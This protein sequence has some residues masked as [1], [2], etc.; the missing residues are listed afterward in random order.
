M[1]AGDS[2]SPHQF[3]LQVH[4]E[5]KTERW[6]LPKLRVDAQVEGKTIGSLSVHQRLHDGDQAPVGVPNVY[7]NEEHQ[8]KGVATAM[9][10]EV[11]RRWPD[12]PIQH[13]EHASAAAQA[14]NRTL[15]RGEKMAR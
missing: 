4:E 7:V 11:K 8:R 5:P 14:L 12:V 6:G 15:G 2:L 3:V 9:Y 1:S 10:A 13:S